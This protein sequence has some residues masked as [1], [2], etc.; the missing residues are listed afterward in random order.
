MTAEF[1]SFLLSILRVSGG[2]KWMKENGKVAEGSFSQEHDTPSHP[3]CSSP[4]IPT[5]IFL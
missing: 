1:K 3:H 5:V 2:I 4:G